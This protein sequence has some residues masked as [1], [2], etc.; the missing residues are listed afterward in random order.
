MMHHNILLHDYRASLFGRIR[1]MV[2]AGADDGP[3]TSW[4]AGRKSLIG[5]SLYA[6]ALMATTEEPNP[7]FTRYQPHF[8]AADSVGPRMR[9]LMDADA[10]RRT[11]AKGGRL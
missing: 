2:E 8:K 5:R 6:A 10:A 1:E 3:W 4:I 7:R 9:L 11:D